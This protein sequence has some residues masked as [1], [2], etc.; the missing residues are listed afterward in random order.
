[1][2]HPEQ[3]A[4]AV[5]GILRN[6]RPSDDDV[7]AWNQ[8]RQRRQL[9]SRSEGWADPP[10][11][12][13]PSVRIWPPD[14]NVAAQLRGLGYEVLERPDGD[15]DIELAGA[16]EREAIERA[17]PELKIMIVATRGD[18][19]GKLRMARDRDDARRQILDLDGRDRFDAIHV[20]VSVEPYGAPERPD[21]ADVQ[22]AIEEM[23]A[24][25][26]AA[27]RA[28]G[29]DVGPGEHP[30]ARFYLPHPETWPE[31][32]DQLRRARI[33][34]QSERVDTWNEARLA[35]HAGTRAGGWREPPI[36]GAPRLF[37]SYR[38]ENEEHE[39]WVDRVAGELYSRG[40][41]VVYDRHPEWIDKPLDA[42]EVLYRIAE[43]TCFVAV[44]T[45]SYSSA[46]RESAEGPA[47]WTRRDAAWA[48]REWERARSLRSLDLLEAV[49]LWRSGP[50]PL[51]L[52]DWRAVVDVRDDERPS[53]SLDEAFPEL[54]AVVV[55]TTPD[56]QQI[57]TSD[58]LPRAFLRQ[59]IEDMEGR[60]GA[61][62]IAVHA[63]PVEKDR[64]SAPWLALHSFD[65]AVTR[66]RIERLATIPSLR[67][68]DIRH[69]VIISAER[70]QRPADDSELADLISQ[71]FRR[72]AAEAK[73]H[74]PSLVL[75]K[76]GVVAERAPERFFAEL[77][78]LAGSY[79]D[80][81]IVLFAPPSGPVSAYYQSE[82]SPNVAVITEPG[83]NEAL[84]DAL[85]C[86]FADRYASL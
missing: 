81:G 9:S 71:A 79:P 4:A 69:V 10:G 52:L 44:V 64:T 16:H 82:R 11:L 61:T 57:R 53:A 37:I 63:A 55:A 77:N 32:G 36:I 34:N 38:W 3:V 28:A 30:P 7:V 56:G 41:D 8:E 73:E 35:E 20:Q 48:K 21:A 40:Y 27:A 43:S 67:D 24:E 45:D 31:L 23:E 5:E 22:R 33:S 85:T 42:Q 62:S 86:L 39:A 51:D 17:F 18:G 47:S 70:A 6:A 80:V 29:V 26:A 58:G 66:E 46:A 50:A 76:F 19:T 25:A 14:N 74:E 15:A 1:V 68:V 84:V 60:F 83:G 2:L 78:G 65:D 13:V 54:T 72:L 49:A 59:V 12:V 75:T